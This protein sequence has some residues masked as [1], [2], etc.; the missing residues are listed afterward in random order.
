MKITYHFDEGN[1][2]IDMSPYL[3]QTIEEF[4]EEMVEASTPARA[5]LF[6]VDESKPL[7]DEK[8]RRLFYR[9]ACR[10]ICCTC[11]GRKDIQPA[12]SFLSKRYLVC[13]EHDYG[14]L[15]RVVHYVHSTKDL[16]AVIGIKDIST[17]ITFVDASYAV[18]MNMR[19]HTGAA[20]TFGIGVFSSDSKM[21]KLNT[22]SSTDAE[23]G[24]I[25][26]CA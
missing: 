11:R 24:P 12:I 21:Q 23:M 1:F 19:S 9:L 25:P 7:V 4:G 14:K 3:Q 16:K 15:R 5:D 22:K 10:L 2:D 18:H 20:M 17:L 6:F 26:N 8:R 13:N